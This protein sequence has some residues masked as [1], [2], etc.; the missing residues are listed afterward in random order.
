MGF[1]LIMNSL[2]KSGLAVD[3]EYPYGREELRMA[4]QAPALSVIMASKSFGNITAI[5]D[6]SF[7]AQ[8]GKIIGILGPV[9]S[10]KSTL[11]KLIAGVLPKDSGQILIDGIPISNSAKAKI[12]YLPEG[13]VLPLY[14]TVGEAIDFYSDFFPDFD[15]AR[16]ESM[17]P[18]LR[19]ERHYEIKQ[20]SKSEREKLQLTLAMSRRASLYLLDEPISGVDPAARDYIINTVLRSFGGDSSI[21]IA[22]SRVSDI[23]DSLDGFVM[24]GGGRVLDAGSTQELKRLRGQSLDEYFKEVFVC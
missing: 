12:S 9:G 8:R 22:T 20:I 3:T 7:D 2:E 11:M 16:A 5:K 13:G 6:A 4:P 19:L 24:L 18:A 21:I 23:Q 15:R 1:S 17:L 10:G 14:F